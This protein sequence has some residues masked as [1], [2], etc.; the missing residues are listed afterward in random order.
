MPIRHVP[1]LDPERWYVIDVDRTDGQR[2]AWQARSVSLHGPNCE[3]RVE[4]AVLRRGFG[5]GFE[6]GRNGGESDVGVNL[7]AGP[8]GSVWLRL[9]APWTQWTRVDRDRHPDDWYWPRH[10]GIKLFPYD[11]YGALGV[12]RIP[13][14]HAG[15][16][17]WLT[18]HCWV[19]E[20]HVDEI[21]RSPR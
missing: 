16:R 15:D 14:E 19:C 11:G 6:L 5:V 21:R 3:A 2:P 7:Y 17:E 20:R 12:A 13:A 4:W 8:I 10:S 18:E 9:R 1:G